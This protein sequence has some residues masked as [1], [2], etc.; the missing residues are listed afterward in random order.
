[1]TSLDHSLLHVLNIYSVSVRTFKRKKSG[2]GL[3]MGSRMGKK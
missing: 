3:G 1:M 2:I